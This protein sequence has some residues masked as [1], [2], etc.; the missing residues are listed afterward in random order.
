[1]AAAGRLPAIA[2][3]FVILSWGAGPVIT[4]LATV[5]PLLGVLFRF[6]LSVP[7]LMVALKFRGDRLTL[8][9][10]R[11]TALPG[12]AFGIN[13]IFVFATVQEATVAVLAVGVA[14]QP[15]LIL[16]V[17]GPMFDERPT[18]V[19]ILWT[20][21]GVAGAA[22]VILGAGDELRASG[23]GVLL[24]FMAMLTFSVYFVLTRLARSTTNVDP[25]QWMAGINIW[26]FLVAVPPAL[27][28]IR[29]DDVA[30]VDR[31]DL[32][33]LAVLAYLTGVIGHVVMSWVHGYVEAARSSLAILGMHVVAV[34]LAW[35]VH[36]EPVTAT[37]MVGGLVVLSAVAAV[38]RSPVQRVDT[39]SS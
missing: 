29:G 4:K 30:Q 2:L 26:A 12:M 20:L 5:P 27:V 36:D 1:M 17:V 21:V 9:L 25:F 24:A 16:L 39:A 6:G 35:P 13:L 28:L 37:Q 8:Q 14:L 23:L 7:V 38:L 34:S 19:H 18:L 11:T 33:W 3:G 32:F 31:W 22:A 10:L 15:A